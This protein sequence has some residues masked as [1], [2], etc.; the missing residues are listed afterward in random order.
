VVS[1]SDAVRF[2]GRSAAEFGVVLS[3]PA[4]NVRVL[5]Y[6]S[7]NRDDFLAGALPAGEPPRRNVAPFEGWRTIPFDEGRDP[8]IV[9]DDL[10]PGFTVVSA[11]AGGD[12]LRLGGQGSAANVDQGLP[13]AT[14]QFPSVWSR[15]P[16][17][18]AWGRY[19]HTFA[20]IRAGD[21]KTRVA[22]PAT[23]PTAGTWELE[24]HLPGFNITNHKRWSLEI[25]TAGG[26]EPVEFDATKAAQ[27]WNLVGEYKL[28]AGE[29]RVEL[30]DKADSGMVIADAVAWSPVR[31]FQTTSQE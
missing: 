21:G 31:T 14:S 25:V 28:P 1:R 27:G 19:R 20:S 15:R 17:P 3:V 16:G 24:L 12:S 26:R 8:R 23:I 7:L 22:M 11:A 6:L 4:L 13:V 18:A 30:S 2:E 9:S 5:P 29:V 10:D